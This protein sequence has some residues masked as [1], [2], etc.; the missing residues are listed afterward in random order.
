[1]LSDTL[2]YRK[3][4]IIQLQRE[5]SAAKSNESTAERCFL[6]CKW[7]GHWYCHL[8]IACNLFSRWSAC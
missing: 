5:E 6:F 7:W 1:M 2:S 4:E 3:F 8:Q